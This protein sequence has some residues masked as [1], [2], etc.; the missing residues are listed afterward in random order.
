[1]VFSHMKDMSKLVFVMVGVMIGMSI[2]YIGSGR[3]CTA[4]VFER[5][6]TFSEMV[7]DDFSSG[8]SLENIPVVNREPVCVYPRPDRVHTFT[9]WETEE[10][11]ELKAYDRSTCSGTDGF[12]LLREGISVR[13]ALAR[14]VNWPLC[15]FVSCNKDGV[16][17][18]RSPSCNLKRNEPGN[19]TV[20]VIT[21][22]T[23]LTVATWP[24]LIENLKP[25][26]TLRNG[27]SSVSRKVENTVCNYRVPGWKF[28]T[29]DTTEYPYIEVTPDDFFQMK[30]TVLV[31][32]FHK[33]IFFKVAKVMSTNLLGLYDRLLGHTD[34]VK[35]FNQT[36][37]IHA[38]ENTHFRRRMTLG[39]LSVLQANQIMN[40]PSWKKIVFL[41]D[42]TERFLS[43][44]LDKI[45]TKKGFAARFGRREGEITF[46]EMISYISSD[47]REP[48]GTGPKTDTHYRNQVLLNR[49]FKFLPQFDFIAWGTTQNAELMLRRYGL[50][51]EYSSQELWPAGFMRNG[52]T[53]R[54]GSE[55]KYEKYYNDSSLLEKVK[56]AYAMDYAFLNNLG[57]V[58]EDSLPV[59]G[60][61]MRSQNIRCCKIGCI[62]AGF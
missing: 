4:T 51:E 44:Y 17:Q 43:F 50:W 55:N 54:T 33:L 6:E 40:D 60:L 21:E 45:G 38:I 16:C 34:V 48:Y 49:F 14:C 41:R 8:G 36:M 3:R 57:L 15:Q 39:S 19:T 26:K 23:A 2:G 35:D 62:P 56:K 11:V 52:G 32:P 47:A 12:A 13:E 46:E 37:N 30:N 5:S 31:D 9:S 25:L 1:M 58:D 24:N 22:R 18:L 59:R 28:G 42:P 61:N 7:E 53:H 27:R 29:R 10:E 20:F